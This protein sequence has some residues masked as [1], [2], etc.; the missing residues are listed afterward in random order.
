MMLLKPILP[1]EFEA[2]KI[3]EYLK[4]F[5]KT[6]FYAP[7]MSLL[8]KQKEKIENAP[9]DL[10]K[11]IQSGQVYYDRGKFKGKFNATLSQE[12]RRIGAKW[13]RS[14][15]GWA[16]PQ[17]NLSYEIRSAISLAKNKYLTVAKTMQDFLKDFK[18]EEIAQRIDVTKFFDQ[19]TIRVNKRL[20]DRS[21]GLVVGADLTPERRKDILREYTK[22]FQLSINDFLNK[23]IVDLRKKVESSTFAGV[24]YDVLAKDIKKSYGVSVN[25]AAFLARQET[26]LLQTTYEQ[27]QYKQAGINEY[28]WR[29]VHN[30]KD[31]SPKQHTPGNVRY[32]HGLNDGKTFSWDDPPI[33]DAQGRRENPGR[34]YNCRCVAI[35]IVKF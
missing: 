29:C 13:D 23:E 5:L 2:D 34:D 30:P 22:N 14:S 11:A 10:I 15:G 3:E 26:R 12:F 19:T 16:I 21:N 20:E 18:P 31:T 7:L 9:K 27:S 25:K 33:V 35:P 6:E 24:R 1:D 4:K 32:Y 17:S 28:I 8:G